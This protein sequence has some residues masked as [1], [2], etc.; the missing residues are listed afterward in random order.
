MT[1]F[2]K[3]WCLL[4]VFLLCCLLAVT[5][6]N[7]PNSSANWQPEPGETPGLRVGFSQIETDNPWRTAQIN[8]FR[9]ALSPNGME[10]IYHE[11]EEYTVEWQLEDIRNLIDQ[12][13]DYLVIVPADLNALTPVLKDAKNAEIPVILIDQAAETIDN[14][15]YA[16]LISADYLKEGEI[17]ANLL[18]D[19]FGSQ[20]CNI[21]EVYGTETSPGAQARSKGFHRALENYPNLKIVDTVY[22]NF[23]RLTAQKAMENALIK[24][25]GNGLIINAVFAH[26]DEDGLGALQAIKTAGIL[27]KDI[28]IVSI[29]G[30]QDVCKAIIA[31]EYL[32]TVESNPR[33]GFIVAFLINQ[34]ENGYDPFP[35]VFIPYQI[36]T[37]ENA[38]EYALTAY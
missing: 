33:W 11:P 26:S 21:V 23:D 9:E 30:I 25:S 2:K 31:G 18:A 32:G 7:T 6:Y 4:V 37:S 28:S 14:T 34:L 1:F 24:A 19:K 17:C 5:L 10:F 29:N 15:Y 13:V 3:N 8:S 36:I 35:T 20:T 27:P 38:A 22:G 12:K 16:S